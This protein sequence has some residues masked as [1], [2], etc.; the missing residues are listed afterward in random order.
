MLER[1]LDLWQKQQKSENWITKRCQISSV[2]QS[3]EDY[4]A[5]NR[6]LDTFLTGVGPVWNYQQYGR[7]GHYFF[8]D[9]AAKNKR[10]IAYAA[11]FG[12]DSCTPKEDGQRSAEYLR[13][14]DAIA[15]D[16]AKDAGIC[17]AMLGKNSNVQPTAKLDP[18]LLC[19]PEDFYSIAQDIPCSWERPFL[20][21]SLANLNPDLEPF[22]M[23]AAGLLQLDV[24][25]AAP[26][27][28]RSEKTA[29]ASQHKAAFIQNGDSL[30]AGGLHWNTFSSLPAD[31]F[32]A[33]LNRSGF[34]V[35][36]NYLETVLCVL[37]HKP[38]LFWPDAAP[39]EYKRTEKLLK[40]L[41]LAS[42]IF[43]SQEQL[44]DNDY[45]FI[46][47]IDYEKA[48]KKLRSQRKLAKEWL[49]KALSIKKSPTSY[50]GDAAYL[51]KLPQHLRPRSLQRPINMV[52]QNIVFPDRPHLD[53]HWWMLYRG[54][55][56]IR[57]PSQGCYALRD[58]E[59]VELFTY[60]NAFSIRKWKQY[61]NVR[62]VSLHLRVRGKFKLQFTGHFFREE[63]IQTEAFPV[64]SF[65]C[66]E[67]TEL[68]LPLPE[69]ESP[70]I[71]FAIHA[72][73]NFE[74]YSGFYGV[75]V[76]PEL[77]N[78]VD[79]SL[80]T[81]TFQKEEYITANLDLIQRELLDSGEEA[82]QHLSI[83]VIDNGR[84]LDA[85][86]FSG[87]RLH[88]FPN[89]NVGGAGGFT[90]GMLESL[91]A[92]VKPTHILLMDDD[93][94]LLPESIRRTYSLLRLLKKEYQ[95]NFISGAML[96]MERMNVQ[97]EDVGFVSTQ[98]GGYGPCK[99]E[100]EMHTIEAVLHNEE[101]CLLQEYPYAGWWYCCIPT[102]VIE[103]SGLPL[104][105]FIRGDDVEYSLRSHARFI[106]L[107]GLC[108]WHMGFTTK[109]NP[110]LEL[111]QVHRNSLMIQALSG[112]CEKVDFMKRIQDLFWKELRRYNYS[113]AD[114]L[115]DA[116]EDYLK[117][118]ELLETPQG[119]QILKQKREKNE[120]LISIAEEYPL[121]TI[122]Y[123]SVYQHEEEL[124][125][126][127]RFIYKK[128]FNG[129]LLPKFMWKNRTAV[130]AYDWFD[131]PEKQ[132]LARTVLAV[133]PHDHTGVMRWP[134]RKD[135]LK[136][137]LRYH[138]L[139]KRYQRENSKLIKRYQASRKE[140][141]SVDFW[142]RYLE[143]E[144]SV[145]AN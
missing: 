21:C 66:P 42:R 73:E 106:T 27:P 118:P 124:S 48:E 103:E 135:F 99:P 101:S 45:L 113:S 92:D 38:F 13:Q 79:I 129:H 104:P 59:H 53:Q 137:V 46:D 126:W 14:F 144:S 25:S 89:P 100:M 117:G 121:L 8:L 81:T 49:Q 33:Y 125:A 96:Y 9:F 131:A 51:Q 127:Q 82:G 55:R 58:K 40:E 130:I 52:L 98:N 65:V 97:H 72:L 56:F 68:V 133:N 10:K 63:E 15:V 132:Y 1:P 69:A 28:S 29:D 83:N 35:A 102:S 24:L 138:K 43:H 111:Y 75:K 143:A 39:L 110:A 61:T 41:G 78:P 114:L 85:Q 134:R 30:G 57:R 18:L 119:E 115:L 141:I 44:Q 12:M 107:G 93:V 71:S 140:M 20:F 122:D 17:K 77:L 22:L 31:Q 32:L 26:A 84:T 47:F 23:R 94:I 108:I 145:N 80:V 139:M 11:S 91:Q 60:F 2:C 54:D 50:E 142:K 7:S 120:S 87:K 76:Q 74:I 123:G 5:L 67:I 90:R 105:M 19:D 62:D 34:V 136:L 64:Q 95:K 70:L 109:Y 36:T 16:T 112:I 116:V 88:I 128:T 4:L 3:P 6:S 37:F 86:K